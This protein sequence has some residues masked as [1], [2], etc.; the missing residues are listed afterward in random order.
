MQNCSE[1]YFTLMKPAWI[2][3]L[4]DVCKSNIWGGTAVLAPDVLASI[5]SGKRK[6]PTVI[7]L[8]LLFCQERMVSKFPV[9]KYTFS[10]AN[11]AWQHPTRLLS[12]IKKYTLMITLMWQHL[13]RATFLPWTL[14]NL[15]LA[16][17]MLKFSPSPDSCDSL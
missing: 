11:E 16:W 6:C 1:I 9:K 2:I 3:K 8:S 10:G 7:W 4:I 15:N 5:V 14:L 17:N 12:K 13:A